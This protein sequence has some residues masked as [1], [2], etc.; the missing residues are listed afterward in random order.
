[1]AVEIEDF[2]SEIAVQ[3]ET[4]DSMAYRLYDEERMS[5]YLREYN[6][7][8]SDVVIFEGGESLIVPV[9][10]EA[11]SKENLAPWRR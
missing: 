6:P 11:E 1:M 7:Q 8:Y 4:F 9:V 3:G 2:Y 5:K 10:S